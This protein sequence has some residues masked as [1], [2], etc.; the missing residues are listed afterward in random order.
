MIA[1]SDLSMESI[2]AGTRG[3]FFA[4]SATITG[5]CSRVERSI[6]VKERSCRSVGEIETSSRL[7]TGGV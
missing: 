2:W 4:V 7:F 3:W 5:H 6:R 1:E